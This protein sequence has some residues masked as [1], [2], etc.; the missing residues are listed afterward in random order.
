MRSRILLSV[1]LAAMVAL[2]YA[3][4]GRPADQPPAPGDPSPD[5]T[6]SA[7]AAPAVQPGPG[8]VRSRPSA[9]PS[10]SNPKA[11]TGAHTGAQAGTHAGA[12]VNTKPPARPQPVGP[13]RYGPIAPGGGYGAQ[14][15]VNPTR[16]AFTLTF[17]GLEI[18]VGNGEQ[19]PAVVSRSYPLVVP[20]TG[21]PRK[22][23]VEFHASG[24]VIADQDTTATLTLTV[25]GYQSVKTWSPD[26]NDDFVQT[27]RLPA[28]PASS[29]HLSVALQLRQRSGRTAASGYLNVLSVDSQIV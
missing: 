21:A 14:I 7:S 6:S 2:L 25:N 28:V 22:A 16:D 1:V 13:L 19:T 8:S 15:D 26:T 12:P 18:E 9:A 4:S 17:D 27:V 5:V 24:A 11:T 20:L 3:C 10:A 23:T 29:Y